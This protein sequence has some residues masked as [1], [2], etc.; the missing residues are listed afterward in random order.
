M[1]PFDISIENRKRRANPDKVRELAES[2]ELIGL[3]N[4]VT[5]STD[6][7][8]IAGFHRLLAARE[9]G[10]E[11]IAVNVLELDGLDLEL[12]EID[13]N[14]RRNELTVLEQ[15]EHLN[16]REQILTEKGLM[17]Q[18]GTS[19]KN[20]GTG[21][22][23][24]PVK[25]TRDLANEIGLSKRSTQER[26]QAA[27]NI[28]P[29]VKEIIAETEIADSTTQLLALAR[30][31]PEKQKAVAKKIHNAEASDVREAV[32]Q[33]NRV[34]RIEKLASISEGNKALSSTVK[35]P[36]VLAD[37]PW[38]Y[39]HVKTD[40]RAIENHYPTMDL[41]EIKSLQISEITQ[42]DCVL[43]MWA[44]SPKLAESL[45]VIKAWGFEY[46]TCA[47]WDKEKI[48]MGY[49]FRQQ[50]ELLL[51][52]VKGSVPT[53]K[54]SDRVSSVIRSVR[55]EHSKKPDVFYEIIEDMYPELPKIELFCRSP[56]KGWQS[57]GNQ[58]NAA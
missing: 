29:E 57:W 46:R 22:T 20:L 26:K 35:Y 53:P 40:N 47:V 18:S 54:P 39:E 33:L 23:V 24:A 55:Q 52:A 21:A 45:E 10:W 49:Y 32:S 36:L 51:V 14:L 5:V 1:H 50:H 56:R 6:G 28:V 13:E 38:R 30:M 16:R 4:P 34:E 41:E 9:L 48:G 12:A 7:K 44:T 42:E 17:A 25:T 15:G 31:A 8:L 58:A 43:F 11:D 27:R 19:L 3:L 37:P 2:M